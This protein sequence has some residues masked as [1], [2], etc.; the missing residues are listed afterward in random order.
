[1]NDPIIITPPST[2]EELKLGQYDCYDKDENGIWIDKYVIVR[3]MKKTA[4]VIGSLIAPFNHKD[5]VVFDRDHIVS[6]RSYRY[7]KET[8][9]GMIEYSST[10]KCMYWSPCN[11][12]DEQRNGLK[13]QFYPDGGSK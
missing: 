6:H 4:E 8:L 2:V 5:G 7:N 9:Q 10:L 1:M 12:E 13:L 3:L 11:D